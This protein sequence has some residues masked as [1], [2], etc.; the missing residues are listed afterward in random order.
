MD[1]EL[2]NKNVIVTGGTRGIGRAIADTF[3]REGANV[4]ICARH[5]QQVEETVAALQATG[6]QAYGGVVDIRDG[7]RLSGWIKE[8]AETMGGLD[9]IVS[10]A[11]GLA[12]GNTADAWQAGF[13][14]DVMGAQ[15]CAEAAMPFLEQAAEKTGDASIIFIGSVSGAEADNASAY[16]GVKAALV[17]LAKGLARERAPK[18]VRANVVSPGTVYFKGGVWHMVEETNPEMFAATMKRNPMGRMATTDDVAKAA[19]FLSSPCSSFTSGV[20]LIVDGAITRRVN[21]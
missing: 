20:N 9:A 18:H 2:K 6:V 15:R 16:G 11:S 19:V 10:N 13:E 5:E 4:A 1:L 17:H 7:D 3:A 12:I 14:I 21:F 8:T